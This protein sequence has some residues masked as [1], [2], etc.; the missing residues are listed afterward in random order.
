[1]SAAAPSFVP[2]SAKTFRRNYLEV[3]FTLNSCPVVVIENVGPDPL[4][5]HAA[6]FHK[7]LVS[8]VGVAVVDLAGTADK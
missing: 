7:L 8:P 5:V 3:I 4:T 2:T 1:M 6:F